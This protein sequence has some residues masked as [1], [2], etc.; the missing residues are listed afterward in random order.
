[1][2]YS[3][4]L[5]A[6]ALLCASAVT[7]YVMPLQS[8]SGNGDVVQA[9]GARIAPRSIGEESGSLSMPLY[10]RH[11]DLHPQVEKR[12]PERT[13]SWAFR[14][15]DIMKSKYGARKSKHDRRQT[16]ALTDIGQDR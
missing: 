4:C 16:I 11:G 5:L 10:R 2:V 15:A 8:A 12:D 1:M 7:G 9:H 13:R 14:Q 6:S 3:P